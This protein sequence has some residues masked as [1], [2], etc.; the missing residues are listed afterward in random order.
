MFRFVSILLISCYFLGTLGLKINQHFCCGNLVAWEILVGQEPKDCSGKIPKEKK[1]CCEN[2]IQVLEVDDSKP[3]Q[4]YCSTE[5]Q[6]VVSDLFPCFSHFLISS[7]SLFER[8][9]VIQASGKAPPECYSSIPDFLRF[10][11][12]R[13]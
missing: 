2:K 12:I 13:I 3:S 9:L 6:W 8:L 4:A 5:T 11:N 10:Q 1:K 7:P